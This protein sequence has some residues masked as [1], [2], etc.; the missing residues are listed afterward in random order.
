MSPSFCIQLARQ[1]HVAV[2]IL[3]TILEHIV[4]VNVQK[5]CSHLDRLGPFQLKVQMRLNSNL[6]ATAIIIELQ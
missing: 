5:L 6:S 2:N 3:V 4:R 1:I